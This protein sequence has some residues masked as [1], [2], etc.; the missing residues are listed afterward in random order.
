MGKSKQINRGNSEARECL[1]E[2]LKK[3]LFYPQSGFPLSVYNRDEDE[4]KMMGVEEF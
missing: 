1:A 4:M 3:I 2:D